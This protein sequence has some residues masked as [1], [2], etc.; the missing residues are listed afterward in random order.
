MIIRQE[1]LEKLGAPE[2]EKFILK[3]I[4]FLD[5]NLPDWAHSKN[6]EEIRKYIED[7]ITIGRCKNVK[8]EINIQRLLYHSILRQI[9]N[10][11]AIA[12]DIL[13]YSEEEDENDRVKNFIN[14]LRKENV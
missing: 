10:P 13:T 7:M 2:K 11:S 3:T 6:E 14:L 1:Q 4:E 12:R 5:E 9:P 8:K